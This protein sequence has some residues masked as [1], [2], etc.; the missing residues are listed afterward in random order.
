MKGNISQK[1]KE[2]KDIVVFILALTARL[3]GG[4]S[5][6]RSPLSFRAIGCV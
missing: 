6:R 5:Y 1:V 2:V 4:N 3:C